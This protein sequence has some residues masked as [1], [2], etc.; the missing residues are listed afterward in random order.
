MKKK[1]TDMK[2][3]MDGYEEAWSSETQKRSELEQ[4]ILELL[5]GISKQLSSSNQ[6]P[7]LEEYEQLQADLKHK[8]FEKDKSE[9]TAKTL[10]LENARLRADLIKAN[11]LEG[12]MTLELGE[13]KVL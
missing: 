4:N 6:L 3:F 10:E 7:S 8:R 9:A 5:Q 13:L 2:Q 12:K 1:E 11:Q